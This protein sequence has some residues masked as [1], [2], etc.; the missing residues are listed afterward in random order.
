MAGK[1][2]RTAARE[3]RRK[4]KAQRKASNAS[5]F[6]SNIGTDSNKKKKGVGGRLSTRMLARC[7]GGCGNIGCTK[8]S[9]IARMGEH[10]RLVRSVGPFRADQMCEARGWMQT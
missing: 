3:L 7:S 1:A 8:C 5:K 4:Q 10:N 6:R 2:K 9:Q